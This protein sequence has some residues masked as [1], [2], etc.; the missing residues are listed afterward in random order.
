MNTRSCMP[1]RGR[2]AALAVAR[3]LTTR[4]ASSLRSTT[5][6][7]LLVS[8]LTKKTPRGSPFSSGRSCLTYSILAACCASIPSSSGSQSNVRSSR[9]RSEKLPCST[10]QP[11]SS[12]RYLTK[13]GNVWIS[14]S[15]LRSRSDIALPVLIQLHPRG[16]HGLNPYRGLHA[17]EVRV[18]DVFLDY[19]PGL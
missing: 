10:G 2:L 19:S 8:N 12:R 16:E 5:T 14:R 11:R 1:H 6:G 3:F 9:S 13:A 7:R 17:L 18:L 15:R 4:V